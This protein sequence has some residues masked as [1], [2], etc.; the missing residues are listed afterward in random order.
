MTREI[1]AALVRFKDKNGARWKSK[2]LAHWE[3]AC[4]DV[5]DMGERSLLQQARNIIGPRGLYKIKVA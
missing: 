3:K 2:L 5:S 1:M 4:A